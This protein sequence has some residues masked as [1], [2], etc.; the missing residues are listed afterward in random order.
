MGSVLA[1]RRHQ[2]KSTPWLKPIDVE[3][4]DYEEQEEDF[5][6]GSIAETAANQAS[7]C[8]TVQLEALRPV[9]DN[10]E[11]IGSCCQSMCTLR[12]EPDDAKP[13]AERSLASL[14]LVHPSLSQNKRFSDGRR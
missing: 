3:A 1:S 8:Q 5:H 11:V 2:R 9:E 12:V 7:I 13:H 10:T 6:A 14:W 4:F